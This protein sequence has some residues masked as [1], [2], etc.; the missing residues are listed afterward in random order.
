MIYYISI[1]FNFWC[2]DETCSNNFKIYLC[3]NLIERTNKM[4]L[5]SRIYYSSV[6]WLFN[7]FRAT[8]RPSSGA[9]NS[10]WS[11]WFYIRF[12]LPVAAAMAEWNQML[13]LQFLNS[14]WWAVCRPNHV[15]QLKNIGIINSTTRLQLVGSFYEIYITMHGSMNIK[16]I[17]V[18]QTWIRWCNKWT[19]AQITVTSGSLYTN[20]TSSRC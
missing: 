16:H 3:V 10:N 7:M 19:F 20:V 1:S 12:W 11:L 8:R 18:Y 9:Q 5:C 14:W 4:Q 13:Q 2:K 15:K 6:S 17:Y